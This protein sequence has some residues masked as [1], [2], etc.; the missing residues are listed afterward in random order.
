MLDIVAIVSI[1]FLDRRIREKY[2]SEMAE[3]ERSERQAM[4][5]YNEMKAQLL[6]TEGDNERLKVMMNQKQKEKDDIL[7]VRLIK[8]QSG[9]WTV[10]PRVTRLKSASLSNNFQNRA[11]VNTV[12]A[13]CS[14]SLISL[15]C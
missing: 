6:E 15:N 4:E 1:F 10:Y 5:K 3:L 9:F 8:F 2:E 13:E 11:Q 7:K 14:S 12:S